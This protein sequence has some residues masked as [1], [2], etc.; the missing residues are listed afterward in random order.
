MRVKTARSGHVG[1]RNLSISL[2]LTRGLTRQPS[3]LH[4]SEEAVTRREKE[5]AAKAET[6]TT[7]LSTPH[8]GSPKGRDLTARMLAAFREWGHKGQLGSSSSEM[9]SYTGA[10]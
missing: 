9:R 2:F 5:M 8:V 3:K 7:P 4:L 1:P 10:R 6:L